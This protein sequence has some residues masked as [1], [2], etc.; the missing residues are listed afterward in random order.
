MAYLDR[1]YKDPN[2]ISHA[3]DE[4]RRIRQRDSVPFVTFLLKFEQVLSDAG[5]AVWADSVKIAFLKGAISKQL[6]RS[7][8]LVRMPDDYNEWVVEL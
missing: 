4:L 6:A 5:G 2:A 8:V 3:T 1:T 7:I